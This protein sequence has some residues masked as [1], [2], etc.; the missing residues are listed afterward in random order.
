[1]SKLDEYASHATQYMESMYDKADKS[2]LAW[3]PPAD[4]YQRKQLAVMMAGFAIWMVRNA[5]ALDQWSG[6]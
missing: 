5:G 6:K 1:M 3:S 4:P 2:D